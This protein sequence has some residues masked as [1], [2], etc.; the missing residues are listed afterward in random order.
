MTCVSEQIT[1]RLQ[2]GK[3]Q[4]DNPQE[5]VEKLKHGEIDEALYSRQL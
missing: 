4:I 1:D 5:T 3:M 2:D